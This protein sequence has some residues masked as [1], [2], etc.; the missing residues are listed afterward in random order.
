MIK[1][2]LRIKHIFLIIFLILPPALLLAAGTPP[3]FKTEYSLGNI[4][5]LV[6]A[7]WLLPVSSF[8]TGLLPSRK[9]ASFIAECAELLVFAALYAFNMR[10]YIIEFA[11]TV[12]RVQKAYGAQV[13]PFEAENA[14]FAL[15]HPLQAIAASVVL[16]SAGFVLRILIN[17]ENNKARNES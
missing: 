3:D 7:L 8:F 5:L 15:I 4:L 2:R 10:S 12:Q 11:G 6:L 1:G 16:F 13:F 17:R 14:D 9:P